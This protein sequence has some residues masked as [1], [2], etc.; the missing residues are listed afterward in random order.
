MSDV[1]AKRGRRPVDPDAERE[2]T[3]KTRT[4]AQAKSAEETRNREA[5]ALFLQ[6]MT[7]PGGTTPR[8]AGAEVVMVKEKGEEMTREQRA[9]RIGFW[10]EQFLKWV[11]KQGSEV[12]SAGGMLTGIGDRIEVTANGHYRFKW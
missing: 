5:E 7:L 9:P 10:T 4:E 1:M 11:A 6:R 3:E 8:E 12:R 2:R